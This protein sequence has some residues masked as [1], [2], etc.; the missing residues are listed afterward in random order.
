MLEVIKL[1][2]KSLGVREFT[3]GL[4]IKTST[5]LLIQDTGGDVWKGSMGLLAFLKSEMKKLEGM[6]IL[7]ISSG[8][9]ALGLSLSLLGARVMMTDLPSMV[10]LIQENINLN[11]E[12]MKEC[13]YAVNHLDWRDESLPEA[14][15]QFGPYD[16][17][18][19][20]DG[21]CSQSLQ[22]C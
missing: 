6:S 13:E 20:S 12:L 8:T 5:R 1:P 22:K 10:T 15:K 7:E 3:S 14:V 16:L 9:G 21:M 19:A 11:A 2:P 4:R 17:V 18:I